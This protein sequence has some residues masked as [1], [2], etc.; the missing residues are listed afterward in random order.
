M[1]LWRR[2]KGWKKISKNISILTLIICVPILALDFDSLF[3]R[4]SSLNSA[5]VLLEKGAFHPPKDSG[6]G[7][8][9]SCLM[10]DLLR[11]GGGRQFPITVDTVECFG[12]ASSVIAKAKM[13][14][15][16]YKWGKEA[17]GSNSWTFNRVS[18]GVISG[19]EFEKKFF[20]VMKEIDSL[21]TPTS[22]REPL[23][24]PGW[25]GGIGRIWI[26]VK[27]GTFFH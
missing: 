18:K 20:S 17:I 10:R 5:F 9:A 24:C 2:K 1:A 8:V 6:E 14:G 27:I 13:T 21:W 7:E 22:W 11:D 19:R 4:R 3:S 26:S 15:A 25:G 16:G 23:V 12:P